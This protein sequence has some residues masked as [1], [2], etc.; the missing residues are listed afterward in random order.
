MMALSLGFG[1][2]VLKSQSNMNSFNC[3][4]VRDER[5]DRSSTGRFLSW[6]QDRHTPI[7]EKHILAI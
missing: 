6:K 2:S 7:I 1:A 4:G 3:E 5:F